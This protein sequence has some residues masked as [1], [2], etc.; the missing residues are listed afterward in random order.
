VYLR[1]HIPPDFDASSCTD[2]QIGLPGNPGTSNNM[3]PGYAGHWWVLDVDGQRVVA[4]TYCD[5]CD[6]DQFLVGMRMVQS[7]TF[8]QAS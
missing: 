1:L 7:I 5:Q 4:Q 8:A 2:R 6:M 3:A